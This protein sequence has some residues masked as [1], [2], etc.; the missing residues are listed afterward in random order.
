MRKIQLFGMSLITILVVVG[1]THVSSAQIAK[2]CDI[3]INSITESSGPVKVVGRQLMVKNSSG[4]YQLYIIKGVGYSPYPVGTYP[5]QYGICEYCPSGAH[6]CTYPNFHP[7]PNYPNVSCEGP[8]N[9]F[10]R[11]DV[12]IDRDFRK[13]QEMNVNTIRTWNKVSP[14]L[15]SE[16]TAKNIKVIAG[17]WVGDENFADDGVRSRIRNDFRTYVTDLKD[18][19]NFS[20]VLFIAIG[21]ENNYR[22]YTPGVPVPNA[23]QCFIPPG[24]APDSFRMNKWY[25]LVELMAM[26]AR[27]IQGNDYR[28]IA[29]VNGEISEIGFNALGASDSQ[30]CH[31]DI[32]GVNI[33]RGASFGNLFQNYSTGPAPYSGKPLW[34]AE[35]GIDSWHAGDDFF[36]PEIGVPNEALQASWNGK[37]WD[38]IINNRAVTIGGTVI[39]YS[40]EYWKDGDPWRLAAAPNFEQDYGGYCPN[41]P[42]H[43][44]SMPDGFFNEEW[45]GIMSVVPNGILPDFVFQR[46]TFTSLQKRF[47]CANTANVFYAGSDNGKSCDGTSACCSTATAKAKRGQCVTNCKI[48]VIES[49]PTKPSLKTMTK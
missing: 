28:P 26:D 42:Y 22:L 43:T 46:S 12:D 45:F 30:L 29:V 41:Y 1:L 37:L 34:I 24:I 31:V 4:V 36:H 38:E 15:L 44:G 11:I 8:T 13:L 5:Y 3:A 17:F 21:N 33:Y 35:Y 7:S 9:I 2:E 39:E 20:S 18:D 49:N 47:Q 32:W 14:R 25:S 40:D 23:P 10:D 16:A 19:P 48:G 27:T 6:T